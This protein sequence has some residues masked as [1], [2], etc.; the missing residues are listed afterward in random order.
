L[1]FFGTRIRYLRS[2][3]ITDTRVNVIRSGYGEAQCFRL[4]IEK[5]FCHVDPVGR[6][7]REAKAG[8][9]LQIFSGDMGGK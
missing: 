7:K 8:N 6:V 2:F 5:G 1:P 3:G 4:V 9:F